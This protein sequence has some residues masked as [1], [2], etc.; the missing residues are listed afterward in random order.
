RN[1]APRLV[2]EQAVRVVRAPFF[3]RARVGAKHARRIVRRSLR[4][5]ARREDGG[6]EDGEE[7]A[8]GRQKKYHARLG[9]GK[10]GS[11]ADDRRAEQR[12]F[13]IHA[14]DREIEPPRETEAGR[15]ADQVPGEIAPGWIA[16]PGEVP[17]FLRASDRERRRPRDD[18]RPSARLH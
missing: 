1:A 10:L 17:R 12:V 16:V 15:G 11:E 13:V 5:G 7:Q 3:E 6:R 4:S 2:A 9:G 14:A 18:E 8:H